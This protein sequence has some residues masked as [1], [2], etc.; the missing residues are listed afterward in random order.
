M[1]NY[2]D[3]ESDFVSRTIELIDQYSLLISDHPFEKQFNYTLTLNCLLGLIV[4]PKER[5]IRYI[6][7]IRLTESF[8]RDMGL[9]ESILPGANTTLK[10]L[11]IKMRHSVAHFDISIE[12]IDERNLVDYISFKDTDNN[13]IYARFKSNEIVPF[14]RLY[15]ESLY[16]NLQHPSRKRA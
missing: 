5:V 11:I 13:E 4:M 7:N 10:E 8:K 16:E 12:S 14:L 9:I 3:F 6:P 2:T 1:G 15:A